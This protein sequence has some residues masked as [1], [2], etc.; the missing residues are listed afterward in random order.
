MEND[1]DCYNIISNKQFLLFEFLIALS[2][3]VMKKCK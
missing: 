1:E 2:K 3:K